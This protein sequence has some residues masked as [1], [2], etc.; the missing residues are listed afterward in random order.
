MENRRAAAVPELTQTI[1]Q[2]IGSGA[3]KIFALYNRA[4]T[5]VSMSIEGTGSFSSYSPA[6][7][8]FLFG[9]LLLLSVSSLKEV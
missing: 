2:Y 1:N 6:R 4:A 5:C 7:L 8:E 3:L 9:C